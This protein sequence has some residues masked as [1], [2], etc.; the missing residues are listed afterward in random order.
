MIS[1]VDELLSRIID[2]PYTEPKLCD[3]TI[4]TPFYKASNHVFRYLDGLERLDW[5]KKHLSLCF[6]VSEDDTTLKILRDYKKSFGSMYKSIKIETSKRL[7]GASKV[8]NISIARQR[9]VQMSKPDPVFF[10][11]SDVIV[12]PKSL[13]KLK[14]I[15]DGGHHIS[16]G[17]YLMLNSD[18][19]SKELRIGV[20]LYLG[21]ESRSYYLGFSDLSKGIFIDSVF[22]KRINVDAIATGCMLISRDVLN[23]V[24]FRYNNGGPSED[25]DFCFSAKKIGYDVI[26]DTSIL[27]QHTPVPYVLEDKVLKV[28]INGREIR[29]NRA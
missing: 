6:L 21:D 18:S 9:L 5:D 7:H 8:Q 16:G 11:D 24:N 13:K 10:I 28:Y 25:L 2:I 23:K 3:V 20:P 29:I 27:C 1:I 26:A 12:S 17:L 15:M 14:N 4:C 22:N 19:D